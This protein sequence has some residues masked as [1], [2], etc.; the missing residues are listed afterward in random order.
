MLWIDQ[1]SHWPQELVCL[2]VQMGSNSAGHTNHG[3]AIR[4]YIPKLDDQAAQ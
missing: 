3:P 2:T 1:F 4:I